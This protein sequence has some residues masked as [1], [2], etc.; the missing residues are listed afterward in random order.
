M[1]VLFEG[2]MPRCDDNISN[3]PEICIAPCKKCKQYI[4]DVEVWIMG[5]VVLQGLVMPMFSKAKTQYLCASNVYYDR[6]RK[7]CSSGHG[8]PFFSFFEFF[9][10]TF[11]LKTPNGMTGK[12]MSTTTPAQ[13]ISFIGSNAAMPQ[14]NDLQLIVKYQHIFLN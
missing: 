5:G 2:D 8:L 6:V 14:A 12:P 4:V 3:C 13:T 10:V 11:P 9:F 1:L 7:N